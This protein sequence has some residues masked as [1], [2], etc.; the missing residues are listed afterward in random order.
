MN[1]EILEMRQIP[2]ERLLLHRAI[3]RILDSEQ[4]EEAFNIST[5]K[6]RRNL[7]IIIYNSDKERLNLWIKKI[8]KLRNI[9]DLHA[10]ANKLGIKDFRRK[11]KSQL[12]YLI[13][14]QSQE[15]INYA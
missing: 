4:F 3:I 8:L 1:H 14:K 5:D 13:Q 6:D 7:F 9:H 15:K 10:E 11:S 2:N 12:E